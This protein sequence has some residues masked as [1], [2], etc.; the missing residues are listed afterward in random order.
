M[1]TSGPEI[2]SREHV[3]CGCCAWSCFGRAIAKTHRRAGAVSRTELKFI[4]Q[5]SSKDHILIASSP[6]HCSCMNN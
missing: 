2:D 1:S 3:S 6:Q 5:R 4:Q